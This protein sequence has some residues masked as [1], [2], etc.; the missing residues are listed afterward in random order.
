[1][2]EG[3]EM[4]QTLYAHMNK[5]KN[6]QPILVCQVVKWSMICYNITSKEKESLISHIPRKGKLPNSF[7]EA[8]IKLN[9]KPDRHLQKGEL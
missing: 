9:P 6:N 3:G 7:Y 2:G 8:S 5:R 1:V 4:T